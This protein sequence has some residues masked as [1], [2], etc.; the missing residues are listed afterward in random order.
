MRLSS[1]SGLFLSFLVGD[2][3]I[4]LEYVKFRRFILILSFK[5]HYYKAKII[6]FW[7]ISKHSI[8]LQL[9]C[10][11]NLKYVKWMIFMGEL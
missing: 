7:N 1:T 10:Q 3:R 4:M 5:L 8:E 9:L 11:I 2:M 6:L